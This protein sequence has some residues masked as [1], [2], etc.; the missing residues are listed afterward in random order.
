MIGKTIGHYRIV[1]EVGRGG[2]GVVYKAEDTKLRRTVALK[3]LSPH[4]LADPRQKARF[5][6]EAQ[7]AAVLDHPNISTIHEVHEADGQT[8]IVM[9]FIEGEDV[10]AKMG[11]GPMPIDEALD[12]AVQVAKGLI[13]AHSEGI[14][15]RDIKPGNVI[16]TREGQ[17]KV[18]DFGLAKLATQT[19][20]TKSGVIMGTV[21]YMS[22]EQA[23]GGEV[24]HRTDIWSL[25]VM[26][27]EM[28]SGTLPFRGEV[29]QAIMYSILN[30]DPQPVTETRK[31][32]PA[33]LEDIIEKALA[34]DPQ[35][36]YATMDE[37]LVDLET[38]RDKIALGVKERQFT[39]LRKLRRRKRLTAGVA[40]VLVV[41][42]AA[43]LAQTF[44]TRSMAIDS[45]AV[46]PFANLSGDEEQEYYSDGMTEQ[47]INEVGK[48][49]ALRVI[50]RT[51]V[52]QFKKT[53]KTVPEIAAQLQVDA[54]IE[55]SVIRD[56]DQVRIT[57]Q[58]I[59][60]DPEEVL[61][62]E[63]YNRDAKDVV[64][65]LGEVASSIADRI[66]VEVTASERAQLTRARPVDPEAHEAYLI[67]KS[68][69][70]KWSQ[71]DVEKGILYLEE[72][73]VH[74][75]N[76]AQA[77]AGLATA[78][79]YSAVPGGGWR[80]PGETIDRAREEANRALE[81]DESLAEAHA[82]LGGLSMVFDW[83][84]ERGDQEL[85]RAIEL[86]PSLADA[87][88][89]YAALLK[90]L[91]GRRRYDEALDHLEL[92]LQTDPLNPWARAHIIQTLV[93]IG[94]IARAH[95]ETQQ[96]LD[97]NPEPVFQALVVLLMSTIEFKEGQVEDAMA[98]FERSVELTERK[99]PGILTS[100][101]VAYE[102][103]G[104]HADAMGIL[105]EITALAEERYV[106]PVLV[107]RLHAGM[108]NIDEAFQS[109]ER[110]Y[111]LRCGYMYNVTKETF[112]QLGS[113]PR[114]ENL[115]ERIGL[116]E[117]APML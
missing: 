41:A 81:L 114:W 47:L 104:R 49:G 79:L 89:G 65:L 115:M 101:G 57:A 17:A 43:I 93:G 68:F 15:H 37:F 4:L 48:I 23:T 95:E 99:H 117:K 27:Y 36:R 86:D 34:K 71:D 19:Q 18:V 62:S 42:I 97:L 66:E 106:S 74:D 2:M 77:H 20:L 13:R 1:A 90:R 45:V 22:P 72:A 40:T 110:A 92:T 59:R 39:G 46:L 98:G 63:S 113:D 100:L 38:E 73:L 83:D 116:P 109:L 33:A 3:F 75:P 58:L 94:D 60:A 21:R 56:G 55:A 30:E 31:D 44:Y 69:V 53:D 103:T 11:S 6:R 35:K 112:A 9:A 64:S 14:V 61:W 87:R 102:M 91:G 52:N 70:D 96:L 8:F 78:Y 80:P 88:I 67:G 16:V 105:N 32:I 10:Q 50:S 111:E 51:T 24:D 54:V 76:Y 108:G 25:G 28:L 82:A 12:I 107:A 84:V 85:Q 7:A 26:L 5:I 29:D